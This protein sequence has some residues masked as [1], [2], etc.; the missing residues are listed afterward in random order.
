MTRRELLAALAVSPFVPAIVAKAVPAKPVG[1]QYARY[2]PTEVE[3]GDYPEVYVK[4]RDSGR[5]VFGNAKTGF[6]VSFHFVN[7]HDHGYFVKCSKG[8]ILFRSDVL[9]VKTIEATFQ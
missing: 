1:P 4:A 3:M 8:Q 9:D 6:V 2:R 5:I 7:P